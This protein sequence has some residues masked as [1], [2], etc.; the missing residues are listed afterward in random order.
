M[1]LWKGLFYC[2]WMSDKPRYQQALARDLA[3]LVQ[4][5]P[6]DGVVPWLR[7]F[8]NTMAREWKGIDV[9]RM[10]K[11][12]YMI[13]VQSRQA[14]LCF[15][16]EDWKDEAKLESYLDL[17]SEIPLNP[18]DMKIPNGMRYHVIDV[19]VDELDQADERRQGKMPIDKVLKPLRKI[20]KESLTKSV[21][22]R[23]QEALE[24]ERLVDWPGIGTR[25]AE[26]EDEWEGIEE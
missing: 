23:A 17:L 21:R 12:L 7:A 9:L 24:D 18:R 25:E 19:Y 1:K 6:P 13:R 26:E 11:F 22:E 5:L 2:I 14:W 4:V 20:Q 8:W 3:A 10:D 15:A 16:T